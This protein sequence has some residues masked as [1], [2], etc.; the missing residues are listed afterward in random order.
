MALPLGIVV[1]PFVIVA[2]KE[3]GRGCQD[4]LV[5]VVLRVLLVP[6]GDRGV[7]AAFVERVIRTVGEPLQEEEP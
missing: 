5:G 7:V 6:I 4:F 3:V 1:P 2:E